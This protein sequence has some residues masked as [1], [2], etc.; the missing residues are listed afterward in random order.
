MGTKDFTDALRAAEDTNPSLVN[1]FQRGLGFLPDRPDLRDANIN[2]LPFGPGLAGEFASPPPDMR[3]DFG[4]VKSQGKVQSSSAHAVAAMAEY[5]LRKTGNEVTE[6]SPLF[7][8]KIA[9]ELLNL[10]EDSGC[11]LRETVKALA[12]YGCLSEEQWPYRLEGLDS[13][14]T[15]QDLQQARPFSRWSYCR[16]DDYNE[17]GERTLENVKRALENGYPVAFGFS[18]YSCVE[19]MGDGDGTI[20]LPDKSDRL[21]GS[22]AVLAVGYREGE[23]LIR[24]SWGGEWGEGGYGWL[25][26]DYIRL[27][28][29]CDFWTIFREG[30]VPEP[31]ASENVPKR[32]SASS[33][34]NPRASNRGKESMSRKGKGKATPSRKKG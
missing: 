33:G 21:L 20:P 16:L 32:S 9:R 28:Q 5:H 18:V 12:N 22:Q 29:A 27:Q 8:Y 24:N 25:P 2:S 7:L 26:F 14:P 23:L 15:I 13:L 10:E 30:E 31:A 4:P 17:D 34:K 1:A 6:L 11:T 19:R 3:K